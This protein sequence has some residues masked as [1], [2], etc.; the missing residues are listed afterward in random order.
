MTDAVY[1]CF[2]VALQEV[3]NHCVLEGR[4]A[5]LHINTPS[6]DAVSDEPFQIVFQRV[7]LQTVSCFPY[8]NF[9]DL[10]YYFPNVIYCEL[11]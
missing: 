6:K 10:M 1:L 11:Y 8:L 3:A 4:A 5:Q 2:E 7:Q 9:K